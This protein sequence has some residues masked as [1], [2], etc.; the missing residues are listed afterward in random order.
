MAEVIHNFI[1]N[2]SFEDAMILFEFISYIA[3][4]LGMILIYISILQIKKEQ[5]KE[6]EEREKQQAE[7]DYKKA[8]KSIEV[9]SI[10]ASEIIPSM[11]DFTKKYNEELRN[12]QDLLNKHEVV[13]RRLVL[14]VLKYDCKIGD[15]FNQLEHICLYI[16]ADLIN[17]DIIFDPLN[18][19]LIEFID[20]NKEIY[21]DLK[22]RA[23]YKY[24][25]AVYQRWTDKAKI[26]SLNQEE[27]KIKDQ[28][29][30]IQERLNKTN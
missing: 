23:P 14:K 1:S 30:E 12:K 20:E 17:E 22:T 9:L 6:F 8:E 11:D 21:D 2:K 27:N 10:F 24:L 25:T 18:S 16:E 19:I 15:I 13:K 7:V 4:S 28:K 3:T 26:K 29:K 5:S